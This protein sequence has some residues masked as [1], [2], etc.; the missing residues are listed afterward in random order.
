M[1]TLGDESALEN[2]EKKASE[3]PTARK[4]MDDTRTIYTSRKIGRIKSRKYGYPVLCDL[5][6]AKI[7]PLETFSL[8]LPHPYHAP[9]V[10]FEM[11]PW[12]PPVDIWNVGTLVSNTLRI[13]SNRSH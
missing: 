2:F 1:L 11:M 9:E 7:L 10:I 12:G 5:G 4:I 6:E 8:I 13:A 3:N